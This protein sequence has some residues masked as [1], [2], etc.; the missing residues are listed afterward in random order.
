MTN[1]SPEALRDNNGKPELSQILF[2][3][4]ALD[5]LAMVMSQGR[6]KYK[7][8]EP[9]VPN[10]TVGGKPDEEYLDSAIRHL[11]ALIKGEFYDADLGTAHAAHIVWN[12]LA[13]LANNYPEAPTLDPEFD[14]EAFAE[15]YSVDAPEELEE[16]PESSEDKYRVL[17]D[18]GDD[19]WA[20]L[21]PG[22]FR[23]L[24]DAGTPTARW[25]RTRFMSS[26]DFI[27]RVYGIKS[28]SLQPKSNF[29]DLPA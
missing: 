24:F 23:L 18:D 12:L 6:Y 2:F 22:K 29:P 3:D 21:A 7:D 19:V 1:P 26:K 13:L 25:S 10:W 28:S 4:T 5:H 20:E 15:K 14:L 11:R 17:I 8:S 27:S 9:G 16:M